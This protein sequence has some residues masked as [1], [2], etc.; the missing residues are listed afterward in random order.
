M[1]LLKVLLL[2]Q[3]NLTEDELWVIVKRTI[4][5]ATKRY[6]ECFAPFDFDETTS[7]DFRVFGQSF[8]L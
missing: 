6:V 2:F 3:V 8:N 5:G 1:E 4:N 7:T